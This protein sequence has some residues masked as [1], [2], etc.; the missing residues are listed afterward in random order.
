METVRES[1]KITSERR[2]KNLY[3]LC[4][5][6]IVRPNVEMGQNTPECSRECD[7]GGGKEKQSTHMSLVIA[8]EFKL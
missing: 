5:N 7:R 2:S 6:C 1:D 4:L 8:L 3:S